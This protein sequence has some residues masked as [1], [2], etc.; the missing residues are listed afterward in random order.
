MDNV[1]LIGF[2]YT[3]K[4]S[5]GR[6]VARKLGWSFVDTDDLIVE[7]AGRPIDE[8]F[9][10]DGEPRFRELESRAV[11]RACEGSEQVIATGGGAVMDPASRQSMADSGIIV[12]LEASPETIRRRQEESQRRQAVRRP[13]LTSE[14]PLGSIVK[15]KGERQASYAIAQWTVH[16]DDLPLGRVVQEVLRGKRIV[17]DSRARGPRQ[18]RRASRPTDASYTV[19]TRTQWYDGYVGWGNLDELGR[20]MAEARLGGAAYVIADA[21]VFERYGERVMGSLKE[22]GF[23]AEPYLLTP[24][25]ATKSL[26]SAEEIFAWL[27]ER[28]AE[29]GHAVVAL[30]GGVAG[31]LGGFVA[32]TYL[33][34][35]PFVQAPTTLL[36]MVDASIGG[37]VAVNLPVG[38]NLVGAFYQPRLVLADVETLTTLPQRE[39]A[40]GWAEVIKHAL[41]LDS[42]L[43]HNI[44]AMRGE[45]LALEPRLTTETIRRSAAIKANVVSRDERESGGPRT[46]LNYGHTLGHALEAAL[47]YQG[48][49]HGEAVAI[50]MTAAADISNQM[51]MLSDKAVSQQREMLEAFGLPVRSP[52]V[53]VEA[54]R[55]AMTLDKKVAG[56]KINW[57]L[58]A[59]I[60]RAVTRSDVPAEVV[61]R[62]IAGVIG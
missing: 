43:F 7:E 3:G 10:K 19:R 52:K 41:I 61:D 38:K 6:A 42:V 5:V 29:R 1:I 30:G 58:L 47:D 13:L 62:A 35:M 60:G 25:E 40:A 53:D 59:E 4:S 20:R 14:D 24:G 45:L 54:V 18:P 11:R 36:A 51:G 12:L 16:T 27:A 2:S 44:D 37:K 17:Q 21:A 50:G 33:R 28:R 55:R 9:S 56:G 23:A 15:L 26:A 34:G 39:A 8:I 22:A 49:L 46:L 31:D 32:A 48:I 57:V